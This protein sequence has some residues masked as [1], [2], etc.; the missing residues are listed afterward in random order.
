MVT[1]IK[2]GPNGLTIINE[3][4]THNIGGDFNVMHSSG[5]YVK[6]AYGGNRDKFVSIEVAKT[7]Y[8]N[9]QQVLNAINCGGA[10]SGNGGN[11]S[12]LTRYIQEIPAQSTNVIVVTVN[13]GI[14]PEDD[15][16]ISLYGPTAPLYKGSEPGKYTPNRSVT[17]N[18]L[19]LATTP[20]VP[21]DFTLEM[22]VP[23]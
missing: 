21:M 19:V 12:G 10:S 2:C 5:G 4:G 16:N 1:K 15:N 8:I 17:P 23:V 3:S 6:L 18:E 7:Q 20:V 13:G 9:T 14:L 22:F 11:G